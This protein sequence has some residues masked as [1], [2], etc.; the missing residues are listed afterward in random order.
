MRSPSANVVASPGVVV[1]SPEKLAQD[2]GVAYGTT[3]RAAVLLC[4]YGLIIT[5]HGCGTNVA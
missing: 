3:R 2:C 1:V 4:E 5:V